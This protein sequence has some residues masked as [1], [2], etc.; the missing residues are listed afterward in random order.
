MNKLTILSGGQTGVDRSALDWATKHGFP[1]REYCPKG[2]LAEDG[3]IPKKYKLMEAKSSNYQVRTRLNVIDSDA[4]LIL[5]TKPLTGG[6][7]LTARYGQEERK[8]IFL[9]TPNVE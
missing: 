4:T 9:I 3:V 1:H 7:D 6:T 5:S 8:T 2:H